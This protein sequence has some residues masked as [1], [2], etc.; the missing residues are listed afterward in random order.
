MKKASTDLW[1]VREA[2]EYLGLS[3]DHLRKM[4]RA[5]RFPNTV[6]SRLPGGRDYRFHPDALEAWVFDERGKV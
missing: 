4:V 1:S 5:G 3:K 2:A 6:C